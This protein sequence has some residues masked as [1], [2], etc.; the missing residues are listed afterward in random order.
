MTYTNL[1]KNIWNSVYDPNTNTSNSIKQ[2]FHP[3][4][5][6]C[7]NGVILNRDQ[8]IQHVIEQK[9]NI[10]ISSMDYQK[11]LEKENEIFA[12]Y[13]AYGK[14]KNNEPFQAE[15]ILYASFEDQKIIKIHGQVRLLMGNLADMNMKTS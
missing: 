3:R 4:F 11:I 7:I 13:F 14:N 10:S 12:I 1:L 8:Y 5:E 15:I 2:F 6:Q 9:N